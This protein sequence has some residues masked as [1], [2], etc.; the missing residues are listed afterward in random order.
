MN[1]SLAACP[2]QSFRLNGIDLRESELLYNV[3]MFTPSTVSEIPKPLNAKKSTGYQLPL[4]FN[5]INFT[6]IL[7]LL[8]V[9]YSSFT[10]IKSELLIERRVKYDECLRHY[11]ENICID[12]V[13]QTQEKCE[14]WAICMAKD[15]TT[16]S[17]AEVLIKMATDL[18][19][20][21]SGSLSINSIVLISGIAAFGVFYMIYKKS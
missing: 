11:I 21:I 4:N 19:N 16:V 2:S 3:A 14:E 6:I 5:P 10:S 20:G 18:V 1:S 7:C 9:M 8:Y 17:E 12:P 15:P 13:P